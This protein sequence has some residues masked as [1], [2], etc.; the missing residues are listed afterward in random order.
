MAPQAG[1]DKGAVGSLLAQFYTTDDQQKRCQNMLNY[2][3]TYPELVPI[4]EKK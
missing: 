4:A 3:Q 2:P 1:D